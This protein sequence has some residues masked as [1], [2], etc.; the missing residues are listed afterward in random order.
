[1]KESFK[2]K[3]QRIAKE[4][5]ISKAQH[6]GSMADF[7]FRAKRNGKIVGVVEAQPDGKYRTKEV[8]EK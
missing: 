7:P 6:S 4:V 1:M 5:S 2:T 3:S 8:K